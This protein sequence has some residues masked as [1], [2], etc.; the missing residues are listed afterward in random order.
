MT[1]LP[2]PPPY[3]RRAL[4][5]RL[6]D[7]AAAWAAGRPVAPATIA[8]LEQLLARA[9]EVGEADVTATAWFEALVSRVGD[10]GLTGDA[11][12]RASEDLIVLGGL[13]AEL[14]AG[15]VEADDF[16]ADFQYGADRLERWLAAHHDHPPGGLPPADRLTE[17]Q[18]T[19]A[20][21]HLPRFAALAAGE[22]LARLSAL[23]AASPP[24]PDAAFRQAFMAE[25]LALEGSLAVGDAVASE[26]TRAVAR[27]AS[28]EAVAAQERLAPLFGMPLAD[29]LADLRRLLG[30][31]EAGAIA[32]ADFHAA[33]DLVA[34][35]AAGRL[36]WQA[37]LDQARDRLEAGAPVAR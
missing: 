29:D 20:R 4:L 3:L 5:A 11:H 18:A 33:F 6:E 14:E 7:V 22:A 31:L 36:G 16:A 9:A 15:R 27:L 1:T 2:M 35:R 37:V 23:L 28:L 34:A 13:I 32:P 24:A 12:Q 21:A 26:R 17:V 25:L 19:L 30:R 8:A 10:A